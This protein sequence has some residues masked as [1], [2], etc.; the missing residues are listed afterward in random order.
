MKR[1][2]RWLHHLEDGLIIVVLC[3]MV[4]LAVLQIILRNFLGLGLTWIDPLLQNGVLWIGM[5]GAMIASRNDGHIQIDL[6]SRYLSPLGRRLMSLGTDLFTALICV[7][8]AWHSFHYVRDEAAFPMM[9]FGSVPA[10]WL[11]VIIPF[12]FALIALRFATLFVLGLAGRRPL[13]RP[14]ADDIAA[15]SEEGQP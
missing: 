8:V 6:G 2:L 1:L 3:S 14:A 12:G 11:Q 5:L 10:W 15:Q 4:L 13:H 9:A 7:L